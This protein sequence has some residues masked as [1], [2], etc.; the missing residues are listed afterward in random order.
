MLDIWSRP[1]FQLLL[2][3]L[4]FQFFR[5]G[6]NPTTILIATF[7]QGDLMLMIVSTDATSQV[8]SVLTIISTL[9]HP[10]QK[11]LVR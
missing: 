5:G 9:K 7:V 6:P 11:R 1:Y 2:R 3:R 8:A 4:N 10:A